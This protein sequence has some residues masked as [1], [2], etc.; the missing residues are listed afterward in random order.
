MKFVILAALVGV[1]LSQ[2][3][4]MPAVAPIDDGRIV[5]G[6][7]ARANSWPWQVTM[8]SGSSTTSCSL[9]CGGSIIANRY[10]LTAAHCTQ[11]S[12][13]SITIKVGAHRYSSDR[14][15]TGEVRQITVSRI[16]NHSSYGRPTSFS[17]D[18]AIVEL[19]SA[20]TYGN[21]VSPVC[22][23]ANEN[24]NT[25]EGLTAFV[26]GWGS[27]SS[28]GSISATLQQVR[29]P[30][31]SNTRC[32]SAYGSSSIDGTMVCLGNFNEGGKDSC[33]G[34]SGGPVVRASNGRFYQ[35][36]VVSWGRGCALPQYPGVYAR[37][38]V[39]CSFIA[40]S[41]GNAAQCVSGN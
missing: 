6:I 36:G 3:C 40:S 27:L 20:V 8:C 14:P 28:G 1:A 5:G 12:A 34:D 15:G 9:R 21:H 16:I 2:N 26:T 37:V 33:Q 11:V 31:V 24:G 25:N 29:V 13:G 17:N 10:V 41:T 23:P 39:Q 35:Y 7:E 18:M 19:S 22:L 4:G 30:F 32:A 38:Q